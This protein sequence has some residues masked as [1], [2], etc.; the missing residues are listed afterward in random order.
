MMQSYILARTVLLLCLLFETNQ[1]LSQTKKSK[2]LDLN[3]TPP[4]ED[5]LEEEVIRSLPSIENTSTTANTGKE[6]EVNQKRK[7]RKRKA[8]VDPNEKVER[9][10]AYAREKSRERRQGIRER[11]LAGTLTEEDKRSIELEK[12]TKKK[13]NQ[14]NKEYIARYYSDY[15]RSHLKEC[16]AKL[17]RWRSANSKKAREACKSNQDGK[18]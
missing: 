17:R 12:S 6:A 13:Y 14:K 1:V 10:R 9:K 8:E 2:D 18:Q 3:K 11:R 5:G 15:R 16:A 4:P 7:K